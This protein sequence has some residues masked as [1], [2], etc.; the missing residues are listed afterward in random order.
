M[1]Q[2]PEPEPGEMIELLREFVNVETDSDFRL[3]CAFVAAPLWTSGPFPILVITGQQGSSKSTLARII[4]LLIDPNA[5]PIRSVPK[6]ERDLILSA[7]KSWTMIFDILSNMPS[8]LSDALCRLSTGG[9]FATRKLHSDRDATTFAAQRPIILN[10]I[11]DLAARPDLAYRAVLITLPPIP[12]NM[13][14]D[15][16]EF[17]AAFS[18]ARPAIVG[19]LL[20][21]VAAGLRHLPH[22]K[23]DR[24]PRMAD[25]A[26]R[27]ETCAAGFG[28]AP[29]EFLRDYEENREDAVA[30]R[31][32]GGAALSRHSRPSSVASACSPAALTEQPALFSIKSARSVP[33][34]RRIPDGIRKT[35]RCSAA[36]C[37]GWRRCSARVASNFSPT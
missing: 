24:R 15:E 6:D 13:R 12:D 33:R 31:C 20:D 8:W 22:I 32:R 25:I 28:W 2:L 3:L 18:K 35:R 36:H 4:R 7:F 34:P 23:L 26:L 1:E 10:S 19:A 17:W 5:S 27:A 30:G 16:S 11:A 14:R 37:T 21:A 9:G 29:G